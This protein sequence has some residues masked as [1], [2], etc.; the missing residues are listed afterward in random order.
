[1]PNDSLIPSEQQIFA[2]IEQ[3]FAQGVR[4]PGYPADEWPSASA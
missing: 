1:M 4:R 2:W 3:I